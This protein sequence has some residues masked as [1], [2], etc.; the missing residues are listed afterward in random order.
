MSLVKDCECST[1]A[2]TSRP[3]DCI[4]YYCGLHEAAPD[5]LAAAKDCDEFF[6]A[7]DDLE[8]DE[9]DIPGFIVALREAI[10]K[11]ERS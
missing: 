11:A 2:V 7:N 3:G 9:G 6:K 5:L 1:E 10:A 8:D 4:I